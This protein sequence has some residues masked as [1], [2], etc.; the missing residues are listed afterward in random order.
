MPELPE[1]ET[2]LRSIVPRIVG[3]TITEVRASG[4][5][6]R[7]KVDTK[8]LRAGLVGARI[9]GVRRHGKY[10]LIDLSSGCVLMVLLGMS[11][12]LLVARPGAAEPAHTHVVVTL[13]DGIELRYVDPR[14]FGIVKLFEQGQVER[15]AELRVLGPDPFGGKFDSEYLARRLRA[16]RRDVKSF[17]LDQKNV[18]GI[19]NIYASEALFVATIGPTRRT[20][21]LERAAV[22]RLFVAILEVLEQGITHRGTSFSNYVDAEGMLGENL[23]RLWVY[24][25][26]GQPCRRCGTA[27]RKRTQGQRS[28]FYCPVCQ[29]RNPRR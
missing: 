12:Q 14:R 25:R 28:T 8:R 24:D 4:K 21:T 11:G 22:E 10:L 27:I 15:A 19:G 13:D 7:S 20:N 9:D 29:A 2:V 26:A 16:T 5:K 3:R 6:L 23:A 1:V 17:L 18:A